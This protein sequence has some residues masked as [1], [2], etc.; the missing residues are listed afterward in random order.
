MLEAGSTGPA[1]TQNA[2]AGTAA[3]GVSS[4]RMAKKKPKNKAE[5]T[6]EPGELPAVA[7]DALAPEH[8]IPPLENHPTP[9]EVA[10]LPETKAADEGAADLLQLLPAPAFQRITSLEV[11]RCYV[12]TTPHGVFAFVRGTATLYASGFLGNAETITQDELRELVKSCARGPGGN[13]Y[14]LGDFLKEL[15]RRSGGLN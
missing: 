4:R 5:E 2:I 12:A 8:A 11:G 14:T 13:V 9:A 6:H 3:P 1:P 15:R 7:F 10:G